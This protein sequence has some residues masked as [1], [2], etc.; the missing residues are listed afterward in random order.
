MGLQLLHP[1]LSTIKEGK[2]YPGTEKLERKGDKLNKPDMMDTFQNKMPQSSGP[3]A[4]IDQLQSCHAMK[5]LGM[6]TLP[7]ETVNP[8]SLPCGQKWMIAQQK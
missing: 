4:M 3:D 8:S 6:C 1:A 2:E 5:N 7:E